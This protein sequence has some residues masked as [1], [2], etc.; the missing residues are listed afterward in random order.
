LFKGNCFKDSYEV[1]KGFS[2]DKKGTLLLLR[3][4]LHKAFLNR[5]LFNPFKIQ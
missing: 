1:C 3:L 2:T 5:K 4:F